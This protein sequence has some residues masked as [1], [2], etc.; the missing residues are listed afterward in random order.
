MTGTDAGTY[1]PVACAFHDRLELAVMR[2]RRLILEWL[3]GG[4][5]VAERV[6]PVD[7][8]TRDGAEWLTL[9]GDDGREVRIRLDRIVAAREA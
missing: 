8:E 7:V 4:D 5:R 1:V 9:L 3:D 6:L 2:R